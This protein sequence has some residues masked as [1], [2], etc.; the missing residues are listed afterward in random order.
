MSENIETDA[1]KDKQNAKL[2]SFR[3]RI[4]KQMDNFNNCGKPKSI[5]KPTT[6]EF[7][8][9]FVRKRCSQN[10]GEK[11]KEGAFWIKRMHWKNWK[12]FVA[13]KLDIRMYMQKLWKNNGWITVTGL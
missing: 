4:C 13:L 2:Q 3:K 10:K 7:E 9:K 6:A 8:Q 1:S 11:S 5:E 12:L